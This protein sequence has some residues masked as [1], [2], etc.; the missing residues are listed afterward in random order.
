MHAT[1][2]TEALEL[3]RRAE[4]R[5]LD[6]SINTL[7]LRTQDLKPRQLLVKVFTHA[8]PVQANNPST[9][10]LRITQNARDTTVDSAIEHRQDLVVLSPPVVI[11]NGVLL[12]DDRDSGQRSRPELRGPRPWGRW[13]SMRVML[14]AK[15]RLS[16]KTIAEAVGVSQQSV[17]LILKGLSAYIDHAHGG[18]A[19]R[20]KQD[21]FELWLSEYPGPGGASTYWYS[22][23]SPREQAKEAHQVAESLEVSSL[24]SGDVAADELAPWR[25]PSKALVYLSEIV[26]LTGRNFS[27]AAQSEATLEVRI[28]EDP[29]LGSVS[30]WHHEESFSESTALEER[31]YFADPLIVFFDVNNGA[32]PDAIDAAEHLK[33]LLIGNKNLA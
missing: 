18:Y 14:L 23:D 3:L 17:S 28:P 15:E 12:L 13:A 2:M 29:T 26:D 33:K 7:T 25:L 1:P 8:A 27:P 31:P 32:G 9:P 10:V 16:Q 22:L 19:A 5:V 6:G 30:R 20:N 24:V 21:L 11:I 4:V